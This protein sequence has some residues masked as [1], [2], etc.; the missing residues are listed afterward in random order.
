MNKNDKLKTPLL[1][2]PSENDDVS[3]SILNKNIGNNDLSDNA[4]YGLLCRPLVAEMNNFLKEGGSVHAVG[5]PNG[6]GVKGSDKLDYIKKC[7]YVAVDT[8]S[9]TIVDVLI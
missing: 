1:W 5:G 3:E 4:L 8:R 9:N 6:V 2:D 7:F